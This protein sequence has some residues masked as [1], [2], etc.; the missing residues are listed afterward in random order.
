[1]FKTNH[2]EGKKRQG[3]TKPFLKSLSRFYSKK[4]TRLKSVITLT[5][6]TADDRIIEV[7]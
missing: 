7:S 5:A 1:M 6:M 2:I 3:N 4:T